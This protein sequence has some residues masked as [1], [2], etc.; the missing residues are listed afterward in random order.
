ME[1]QKFQFESEEQANDMIHD[2]GWNPDCIKDLIDNGYIRKSELQTLVDEAEDQYNS[3]R[4]GETF[5]SD[6]LHKLIEIIQALKK[7]YPE[8]KE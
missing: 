3:W 5:L 4:R 2:L 1:K 6:L 8:F 7:S